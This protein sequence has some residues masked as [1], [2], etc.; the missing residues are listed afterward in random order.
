LEKNPGDEILNEINEGADSLLNVITNATALSKVTVGDDIEKER[1]NLTI[2]IKNIAEEFSPS[3]QLP[4]MTLDM[5]LKDGIIVNA[6]PIIGEIFRNYISNAIKYAQTGKQIV[7][8]AKTYNNNITVNVKDF[9]ETI[10][11][12]D[13]KKIFTREY[14]INN[15]EGRGLGLSIVKRIAEAHNAKVG[16]K[17]NVPKGNNFYLRLPLDVIS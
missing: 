8:D 13:R 16:V 17:P 9:G 6:N 4:E 3:L 2:M 15:S 1:L 10:Q 14:Q 5:Q 7:V 11:E 12:K